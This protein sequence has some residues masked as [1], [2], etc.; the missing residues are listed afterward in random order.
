M[1]LPSIAALYLSVKAFSCSGVSA[2]IKATDN[3]CA[4]ATV[5]IFV[6]LFMGATV[7]GSISERQANSKK[8]NRC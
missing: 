2:T 4:P 3:R 7:G 8:K 1:F 6:E 5:E